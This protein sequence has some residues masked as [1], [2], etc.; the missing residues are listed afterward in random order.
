[1]L[2]T[3]FIS[4]SKSCAVGLF[5]EKVLVEYCLTL[6][7]A[8]PLTKGFTLNKLKSL[9]VAITIRVLSE[10]H[11]INRTSRTLMW[12]EAFSEEEGFEGGMKSAGSIPDLWVNNISV[13]AL[14][15]SAIV[16]DLG[17]YSHKMLS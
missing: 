12:R 9:N 15:P 17:N 10:W 6:V 11:M 3:L 16:M 1:M 13:Y 7:F 8:D 2:P 14:L 4:E 5:L